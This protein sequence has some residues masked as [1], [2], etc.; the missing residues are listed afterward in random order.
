MSALLSAA[1]YAVPEFAAAVV[2]AGLA[3]RTDV[4]ESFVQGAKSAPSVVFRVLPYTVAMVFAVRLM[5]ASGLIDLIAGAAAPIFG[6]AAAG[7]LPLVV[8][9]PFSGGGSLGV[10]SALMGS[11][12]PDSYAGRVAAT[13][14]G[15]SET[16]FYTVSV[17]FGSAG[18]KRTRY[19]I[20]VGLMTDIFGLFAACAAVRLVYG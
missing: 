17:Y 4:Y 7:V 8:M 10:L 6:P 11:L 9:R 5:E 20:P 14:M 19:V 18:I 2:I 16:L 1:G 3:K 15:S 12:G 13:Y